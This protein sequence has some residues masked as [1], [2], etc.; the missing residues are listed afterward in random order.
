MKLLKRTI[1]AATPHKTDRVI[2]DGSLPG[3]GIRIKPTGVKSFV[4]QY[5]NA[6]G[7]SRRKTL[8]RYGPLTLDAARQ[9]AF[10]ELGHVHEG[11]D[12][13]QDTLEARHAMTVKE[14]GERFLE[15]HC[16]GAASRRLFMR[17]GISSPRRSRPSWVS[18][19][20][21][22]CERGT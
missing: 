7:R 11:G 14:L 19:E 4:I 17:I 16:E 21:K 12:P 22:P 2:W 13:R 5:R 6:E 1:D 9:L 8:G 3:F 20:L 15:Q 10:K 18:A